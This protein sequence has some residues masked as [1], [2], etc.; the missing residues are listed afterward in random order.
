MNLPRALSLVSDRAGT[1]VR[2]HFFTAAFV[3]L[4][5]YLRVVFSEYG[6]KSA[7]GTIGIR[8]NTSPGPARR[9]W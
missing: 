7:P 2:F 1:V 8:D 4:G 6:L 9:R 5:V 3:F